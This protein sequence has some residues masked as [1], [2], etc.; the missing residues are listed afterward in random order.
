MAHGPQRQLT[1]NDVAKASGVSYQTVSRVINNHPNVANKTRARVLDVIERLGYRPNRAARSLVTRRSCTVGIVSYG[2]EYYGPSRMLGNIEAALRERGYS[3]GIVSTEDLSIEQLRSAVDHLGGHSVDGLVFITPI[4]DVELGNIAELCSGL[5]FVMTDVPLDNRIPSV[6]IDQ[7]HGSR[8]VT[9]HL[10]D[11]GHQRI[12]EARGPFGWFDA[13]ERHLA[14]RETMH[15]AGLDPGL[16]IEGDWTAASG[17]TAT[18][19]LLAEAGGFTAL[20]AGNDQ[21]ALG[22]IRA[23]REA[24]LHVPN[25]VSVVGFD[26]VPEAAYFEPPLTTVQQDFKAMGQQTVD[27]LIAAIEGT[28]TT[29]HRRT[30]YPKLIERKSARRLR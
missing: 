6:V 27:Y 30:L 5:P 4:A 29:I 21:M 22:A 19:E 11:L 28:D 26:D 12:C 25:D 16:S 1:L 2:I 7:R 9:Q 24:G 3:L 13:D 18:K 10:I 17:Y 15:E 23:L 14:W 20:V 8:L